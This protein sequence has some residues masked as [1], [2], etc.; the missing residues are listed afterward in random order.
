MFDPQTD[1]ELRKQILTYAMSQTMTDR[2]RARL[3]GLPDGCRIRENAKI[4]FPDKLV[5]G[6]NVWIGEGAV[7]DASGGL[8]IGDNTQI[9]LYTLIFSHDSVFQALSGET[10]TSRDRIKRNS[11]KIGKNCFIGGLSII[12]PGVTIG[13]RSIVRPMSLVD[14]DVSKGKV[15]GGSYGDRIADLEKRIVELERQN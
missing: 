3:L 5:C 4:I 1:S 11:V 6:K 14:S 10:G 9:G 7:L 8:E 13:D 15:T 12:L 2:E